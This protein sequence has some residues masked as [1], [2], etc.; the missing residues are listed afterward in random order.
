MSVSAISAFPVSNYQ[1]SNSQSSFRQAFGALVDAINSG[2]LADAQQAYSA[3]SQLQS[4][5]QGTST[6]PNSPLAQALSQIGQDLQ[7]NNLQA[8]QQVLSSLQQ[9]G[10]HHHH[11]HHG[12][13]E[14]S[15]G[16]AA[17]ATS[18]SASSASS[19]ANSLNVTA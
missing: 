8:A 15:G 2:N 6:N 18:S 13:S 9:A 17:S 3:L 14:S 5:G 16:S 4:S 1:P 19:I 11:G 7:S 10:H 12:G